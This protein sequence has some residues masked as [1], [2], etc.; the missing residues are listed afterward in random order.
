MINSFKSSYTNINGIKNQSTENYEYN[1]ENNTGNFYRNNN[2]VIETGK[3][4]HKD[5]N[6]WLKERNLNTKST[7]LVD[8]RSYS[9]PL[10]EDLDHRP[11]LNNILS[12]KTTEELRYISNQLMIEN[13]TSENLLEKIKTE[14]STY[15]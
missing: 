6:T 14:I 1:L 15:F 9:Q 10:I 4:T 2:G 13:V 12:G 11:D 3:I 7:K 5:F 8:E